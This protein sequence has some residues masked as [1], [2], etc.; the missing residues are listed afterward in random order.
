M[1]TTT[2]KPGIENGKLA[3]LAGLGVGGVGGLAALLVGYY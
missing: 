1:Q 3:S 2:A